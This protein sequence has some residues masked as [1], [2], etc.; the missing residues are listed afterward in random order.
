MPA[1]INFALNVLARRPDGYHEIESLVAAVGLTDRVRIEPAAGD[2]ITLSIAGE[3]SPAGPDNLV[4]RAA[5]ALRTTATAPLPR[6]AIALTK[7]IPAGAGLGG[8]SAD[9]AAALVGLNAF[10]H[11][12]RSANELAQIAATLGADVPLF[13]HLPAAVI[14]GVGERVQPVSFPWHGTVLLVKPAFEMSTPL[15]YRNWQPADRNP[16]TIDD[17]LAAARGDAAALSAALFNALL[18]AAV[19]ALPE[20]GSFLEDVASAVGRTV[21]LTGSG[22]GVFALYDDATAARD[23]Q[24]RLDHRRDVRT[25]VLPMWFPETAT[26]EL[27]EHHRDPNQAGQ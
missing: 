9:A 20:L 17:V 22:S 5:C 21:H 2:D 14:R 8:G 24:Q 27:D 4:W 3:A 16:A 7:Q 11:L 1:K 15:V 19:R 25:W 6:A 10:W 13:L 12:D 18:P 26:G 23:A